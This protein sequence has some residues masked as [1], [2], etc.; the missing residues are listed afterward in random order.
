MAAVLMAA[1]G[2]A[3]PGASTPAAEH[4]LRRPAPPVTPQHP[5]RRA[6]LPGACEG[7]TTYPG[8]AEPP[9]PERAGTLP[10]DT[11]QSGW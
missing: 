2:G 5:E 7:P 11:F 4:R 9:A 3:S 8:Y 6:P 10:A 1:S